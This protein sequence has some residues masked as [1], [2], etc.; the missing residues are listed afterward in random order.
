MRRMSAGVFKL[1]S[2]RTR[3]TLW[4]VAVLALALTVFAGA[5]CSI[6]QVNL[7]TTIKRSLMQQARGTP[8]DDGPKIGE[9]PR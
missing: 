6:V 2:V 5:L 8:A 7:D 4:S 3:L 9:P 1:S